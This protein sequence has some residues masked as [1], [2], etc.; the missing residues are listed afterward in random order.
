MGGILFLFMDRAFLTLMDFLG[1]F[2]PP[3]FCRFFAHLFEKPS[4][5]KD[6]FPDRFRVFEVVSGVDHILCCCIE[7]LRPGGDFVW[8]RSC[9]FKPKGC[10]QK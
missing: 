2:C 1:G 7:V 10:F 5:E 4:K 9:C 3:F 8:A 6:V